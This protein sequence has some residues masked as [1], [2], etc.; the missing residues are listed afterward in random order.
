MRSTSPPR[1]RR[2]VVVLAKHGADGI[3]RARSLPIS[4][5]PVPRRAM[6]APEYVSA[7]GRIDHDGDRYSVNNA[8]AASIADRELDPTTTAID[9]RSSNGVLQCGGRDR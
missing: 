3:R 5:F 6:Y 2:E 4:C 8:A 9:R 1:P 7:P